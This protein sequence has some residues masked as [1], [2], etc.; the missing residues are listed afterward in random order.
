MNVGSLTSILQNKIELCDLHFQL[1]K[2]RQHYNKKAREQ[3][4]TQWGKRKSK[5]HQQRYVNR[6]ENRFTHRA[7]HVVPAEPELKLLHE[8]QLG[9]ICISFQRE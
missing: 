3:A 6:G 7:G 9:R 2:T 1:S 8:P 4:I 5:T